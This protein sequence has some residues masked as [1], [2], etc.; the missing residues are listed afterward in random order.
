LLEQRA[1]LKNRNKSRVPWAAVES[2]LSDSMVARGLLS[3]GSLH[4]SHATTSG[5]TS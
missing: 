5:S 1:I 3:V 4:Y 2:G